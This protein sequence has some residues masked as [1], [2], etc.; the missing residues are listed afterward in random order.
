MDSSQK[1][2]GASKEVQSDAEEASKEAQSAAEELDDYIVISE[3]GDDESEKE[4]DDRS[5]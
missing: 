4:E 5:N 3:T 1:K 2:D